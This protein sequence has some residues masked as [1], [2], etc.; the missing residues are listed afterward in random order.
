[1]P[2]RPAR[3]AMSSTEIVTARLADRHG[4]RWQARDLAGR[5]DR[6]HDLGG[7]NGGPMAS[8]HVLI[9]L[10][11]CTTTTAVKI[12]EKRGVDLRDVRIEAAMDFDE[13][14]EASGIRLRVEVESASD[15]RD[16]LKVFDLAERACTV[17]KLLAIEPD[18][19][20]VVNPAT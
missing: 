12:A 8:E 2:R 16:V 10:A 14:G 19:I 11:S 7:E 13:R 15:E 20:V 3:R 17:S 6:P 4:V 18:R 5:T 9:A 1:M